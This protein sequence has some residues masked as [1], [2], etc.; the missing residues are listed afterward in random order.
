[1]GNKAPICSWDSSPMEISR[2]DILGEGSLVLNHGFW[3]GLSH[4]R[5][6][7]IPNNN[8]INQLGSV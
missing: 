4:F 3:M 5:Q 7:N 8:Q 1:M 2:E 6:F